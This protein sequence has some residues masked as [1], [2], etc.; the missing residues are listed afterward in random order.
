MLS[1]LHLVGLMPKLVMVDMTRKGKIKVG[2]MGTIPGN[3]QQNDYAK[4]LNIFLSYRLLGSYE[5]V[6]VSF[7]YKIVI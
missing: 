4:Y 5:F 3:P 1:R 6:E 2:P 7:L